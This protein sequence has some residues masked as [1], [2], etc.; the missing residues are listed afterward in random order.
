MSHDPLRADVTRITL[1]CLPAPHAQ[2]LQDDDELA[3]FGLDSLRILWLLGDI[4][5]ELG[6]IIPDDLFRMQNFLTFGSL[7][8][9]VRAARDAQ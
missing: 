4:D 1:R 6:I 8:A 7:M 2:C 9:T 3:A 5:R